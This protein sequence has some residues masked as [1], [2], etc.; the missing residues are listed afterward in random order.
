[1][2]GR[3]ATSIAFE[4]VA[5]VY[6]G[7]RRGEIYGR[8]YSFPLSK[9]VRNVTNKVNMIIVKPTIKNVNILASRPANEGA[10][11]HGCLKCIKLRHIFLMRNSKRFWQG[12]I[13]SGAAIQNNHAEG[14]AVGLT[15]GDR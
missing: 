1:M 13:C 6:V 11:A 8:F 14:V 5:V 9:P 7:S 15:G 4:Y 3:I 10:R 2:C 12:A